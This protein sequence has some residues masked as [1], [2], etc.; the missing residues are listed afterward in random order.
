MAK[1]NKKAQATIF[2]VIGLIIVISAL[3][4]FFFQR[5]TL[6]KPIEKIAEE[7]K[8]EFAGQTELKGYVDECLQDV[9]LQG[10]EIIRLQGGYIDIPEDVQTLLVKDIDNNYQIKIIDGS[11][12][13]VIDAF[14][15]GNKVPF[16]LTKDRLAVPSITL[17]ENE[18]KIYVTQELNKCINDFKPFRE[19]KFEINYGDITTEVSM[20]N[21]VTIK[22]NFPLNAKRGDIEFDINEFILTVPID[23]QLIVDMA[24]GITGFENEASFL[25][26]HTKNLISLYSA[27]DEERLPPFSQTIN[28]LDCSSVSWSKE[29]VKERLKVI[30]EG[31]MKHLKIENT[32]F[33]RP[34]YS[35][36]ASQN[37]F[38]SFIYEFFNKKFPTLSI[39]FS[40]RHEWE[41]Y[42]YDINPNQGNLIVPNRFSHAVPLV[43]TI[44]VFEYIY[45]YTLNVPI[46]VEI[47]DDKSARIDPVSNVYYSDEGFK[48]QFALDSYLCGNQNRICTGI[49]GVTTDFSSSLEE[50]NV[51]VLP[52]SLFCNVDQRISP[53]ISIKTYDTDDNILGNVDVHYRCGSY[54][55]DCYIGRTDESGS[56]V[57]KFPQCING[58]IF[59]K[60]KNHAD[61][62]QLLTV[63]NS[64]LILTF[65]LESLREVNPVVKRVDVLNYVKQYHETGGNLGIE[66][67]IVELSSEESATISA[68]GPEIILYTY[69]DPTDS[70]IKISSGTYNLTVTMIG[71][72]ETEDTTVNDQFFQSVSGGFPFGIVN[73]R[74]DVAK[75]LR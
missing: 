50:A 60:R 57:T 72:I 75:N 15:E 46:F 54:K 40:Y 42:E 14:G 52:E 23:M 43:G 73:I 68:L 26:D 41:F 17:M 32:K 3:V 47:N 56:L 51:T 69:P 67:V 66:N 58:L 53:N 4:I 74:W 18:L 35:E 30:F 64:P 70:K 65:N 9:V 13:V 55:N 34:V 29:Q 27:L 63:F 25:E 8:P 1:V 11:K 61:S 44:C 38:E 20:A 6:E 48:L 2:M 22:I 71:N 33:D 7:Q 10:L 31:F 45:K 5:T 59:L 49:S 19:Q 16:W 39:D 24:S 28:N 12:K 62:S 21:A 36:P 37:I